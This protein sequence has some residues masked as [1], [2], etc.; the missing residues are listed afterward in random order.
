VIDDDPDITEVIAEILSDETY[1]PVIWRK[2]AGAYDFIKQQR[3]LAVILD[4]RMETPDAGLKVAE[5]LAADPETK[6][7][8][9]IMCSGEH[10]F[11]RANK[12]RLHGLSFSVIGKPFSIPRLQ[13]ILNSATLRK[14]YTMR[15]G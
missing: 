11:V 4:M 10:E 12:Q 15:T 8:P 5:E 2:G 7:I 1:E 9:I 13:A 14:R 3:P 6:D